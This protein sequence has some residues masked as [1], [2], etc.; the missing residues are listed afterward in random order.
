MSDDTDYILLL[1]FLKGAPLS[2]LYAFEV[3][4]E[5]AYPRTLCIITGY[6]KDEILPALHLLRKLNLAVKNPDGRWGSPIFLENYESITPPVIL[7]PN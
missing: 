7:C 2:I 3:L 4:V 5:P 1:H 6:H